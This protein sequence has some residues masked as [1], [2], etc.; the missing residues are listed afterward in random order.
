MGLKPR[1]KRVRLLAKPK[2]A[3]KWWPRDDEGNPAWVLLFIAGGAVGWTSD[4]EDR[5]TVPESEARGI[6]EDYQDMMDR[7]FIWKK[8]PR[9]RARRAA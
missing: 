1:P 8:E 6:A 9:K 2:R 7:E 4:L 5:H 3:P